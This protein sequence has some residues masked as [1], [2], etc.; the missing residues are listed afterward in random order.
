MNRNEVEEVLRMSL[1]KIHGLEQE[2][3]LLSA[4]VRVINIFEKAL[5]HPTSN[6]CGIAAGG[7]IDYYI[8]NILDKIEQ[9]KFAE[10]QKETEEKFDAAVKKEVDHV[11]KEREANPIVP[12]DVPSD[13]VILE[14]PD[15]ELYVI[16]EEEEIARQ[17]RLKRRFKH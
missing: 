16:K 10:L 6:C 9:E 15:K 13:D 17:Q 7:S 12:Q 4:Q 1:Q 3:A 5:N 14:K 8:H 11:L 2:N